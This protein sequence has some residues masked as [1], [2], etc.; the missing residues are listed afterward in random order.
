[1]KV[2]VCKVTQ[3]YICLVTLPVIW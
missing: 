1:M 2:V 3:N